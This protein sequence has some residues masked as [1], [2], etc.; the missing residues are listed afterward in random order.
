MGELILTE[1]EKRSIKNMYLIEDEVT[2]QNVV[3]IKSPAD[4]PQ[5]LVDG[6]VSPGKYEPAG[7]NPWFDLVDVSRGATGGYTF[8]IS[9]TIAN[10]NFGTPMEG[11]LES[12]TNDLLLS[13]Q[14]A[15]TTPAVAVFG[16]E[17]KPASE[18]VM[19]SKDK[20]IGFRSS[21]K[22]VK[23]ACFNKLDGS[24]GCETYAWVKKV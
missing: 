9:S 14:M 21:D 10:F 7:R 1:E 18:V 24:F 3:E 4:V 5:A 19:N 17:R 2:K 15:G 13:T 20:W 22:K 11:I 16:S 8:R 6:P 12:A 23:F